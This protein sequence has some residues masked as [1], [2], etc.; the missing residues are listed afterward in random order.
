MTAR[1]G[2]VKAAELGPGVNVM[3][4][5]VLGISVKDNQG[6]NGVFSAQP[7]PTDV[8]Q[9]RPLGMMHE[10]ESLHGKDKKGIA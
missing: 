10:F 4:E 3:L 6:F 9:I 7:Q 1:Q 2:R 5:Q 8:F